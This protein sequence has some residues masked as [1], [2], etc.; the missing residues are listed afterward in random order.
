LENYW[1]K[2]VGRLMTRAKEKKDEQ[3][4][5]IVQKLVVISYKVKHACFSKFIKQANFLYAIA[6]FQW[7]YKFPNDVKWMQEELEEL[8]EQR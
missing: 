3:M 2:L 4:K 8:I 7:R 6:F 1:D 5:E